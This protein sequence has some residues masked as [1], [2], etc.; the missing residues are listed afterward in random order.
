MDLNILKKQA[1]KHKKFLDNRTII[2]PFG[3][4]INDVIYYFAIYKRNSKVRGYSVIT[5]SGFNE[6]DAKKA[7][8]KLV[9]FTA[10]GNNFFEIEKSKMKLSPESLG[11]IANVIKQYTSANDNEVLPK[12]YKLFSSLESNLSEMQQRITDYIKHY[13][14]TIL[15]NNLIDESE[16][17]ILW[18][19]LAHLNRLQYIQ[20][21]L[22]IENFQV[23]V[24]TYKE[25]R[26]H[27]LIGK[28]TKYDQTVL[29]ELSNDLGDTKRSIS[30]FETEK[31]IRNLPI[32]EQ[33]DIL[34]KK[35][36][37]VGLEKL[38]RYKSDLRYPK[39]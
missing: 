12:G 27:R 16:Q 32:E 7:F 37:E 1:D 9:I 30:M 25:M 33:V 22:L 36:N 26:E 4:R 18:E 10:Y 34:V 23:M 21:E 2:N 24:S 35:F 14:N 38:N 15:V 19:T 13:D 31:E 5:E 28:L 20:G 8:E 3:Y 17:R 29:K 39:P 6:N 11:N